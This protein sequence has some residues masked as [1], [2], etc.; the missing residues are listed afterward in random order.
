MRVAGTRICDV[1]MG[2]R[3]ALRAGADWNCCERGGRGMRNSL[4]G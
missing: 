3:T 1:G 4:C 2:T